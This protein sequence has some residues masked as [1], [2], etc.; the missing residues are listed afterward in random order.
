MALVKCVECGAQISD[1][2]T[3]C[4][5]CGFSETPV[6]HPLVDFARQVLLGR[7][8]T[9]RT[10]QDLP[11]NSKGVAPGD[12]PATGAGDFHVGDVLSTS[13]TI[14]KDQMG[15]I[16]GGVTIATI[17]MGVAMLPDLLLSFADPPRF[18]GFLFWFPLFIDS[19]MLSGVTLLLLN[20][21]KGRPAKIWDI[22][23]GGRYCH[24]Y[25]WCYIL[26]ILMSIVGLAVFIIPGIILSLMFWMFP[27][28]L[29]DRDAP[30]LKALWQSM[31]LTK[32][33]LL[34]LAI[35]GLAVLGLL[36]LGTMALG[37]GLFFTIPLTYLIT[38]VA[39]MRLS[40]QKT[41]AD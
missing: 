14:Y 13:W 27:C 39:Y 20:V 17:I 24:R 28:I 11:Q 10:Q 31:D 30:G 19:V 29:V 26:S 33:H 21:V 7:T 22:F 4:P 34:K 9:E 25:F 40:G 36:L 41:I 35:L 15:L 6:A 5:Q 1:T 2:A 37:V 3:S 12:T 8:N 18:S 16:L 38:T 32:D 23:R